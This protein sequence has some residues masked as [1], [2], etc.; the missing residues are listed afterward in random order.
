MLSGSRSIIANTVLALA[1]LLVPRAAQADPQWTLVWDDE[2]MGAAN[3]LPDSTRWTYDLG[4][5]G[6]GNGE[7]ETYTNSTSNVYQTGTGGLVIQALD[8]GGYTSARIK[9]QTLFDQAYGMVE[10]SIQLPAGTTQGS[11]LWPAF[12]M[13]GSNIDTSA[14]PL[15]GEIDMME[16]IGQYNTATQNGGHIHGPIEPG[17]GDYNGGDGVGTTY[18]LPAGEAM[19]TG[20]HVYGVQWNPSSISYFV[21]GVTYQTLS[22][23]SLPAGGAWVFNHPFFIILNLA[24]GGPIGGAVTCSFPQQLQVQY[25]RVFKLTDNGTSAYGGTAPNL[26]GTVQAANYDVY[27]DTTDPGEPGEGFAYNALN[28]SNTSGQYRAGDAISIEDCTDPSALNGGY[29]CDYTSPGQWM[30][31]TVNVTQAGSY[32]LDARVASA[33]SGGTFHFDVDGGEV[34]G[35]LTAPN[36]GGWQTW[37]DVTES[38]ISLTTGK[39]VILLVEDSMLAG[40]A[41]VC[42]FNYFTFSLAT[43]PSS[44]L[45]SA[46]PP[47]PTVTRTSTPS[48]TQT[49]TASRTRTPSPTLSR[50]PTPSA[51]QSWTTTPSRTLSSTETL[52]PSQSQTQSYT[53]SP[54]ATHTTAATLSRTPTT[55]LTQSKTASPQA[56]A[57]DTPAPPPSSTPTA[58]ASAS[59]SPAP[60]PSPTRT[61][62]QTASSS[63]T[64]T[65]TYSGSPSESPSVTLSPNPT[66]SSTPSLSAKP[67]LSGSPSASLTGTLGSSPSPSLTSSPSSSATLTLTPPETLTPYQTL[68]A[69]PSATLT[70]SG[71]PTQT[72]TMSD[73]ATLTVSPT[74]SPF[75]SPMPSQSPSPLPSATLPPAGSFQVLKLQPVPNPQSGPVLGF[76][77]DLEGGTSELEISIFS[78]AMAEIGAWLALGTSVRAGT[79]SP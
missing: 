61:V 11:G 8:N 79:A 32:T 19:N 63:P 53:P 17:G 37:P 38:G 57:S 16:N 33:E 55:S 40:G 68:T 20:F 50:S 23:A 14:W 45:T 10:A 6:W 66:G 72:S 25:V 41:G 42:N 12:W 69:N 74:P 77:V 48:A 31:Y 29:D 5:G 27:D 76:A 62:T 1:L 21:D 28:A 36:T 65:P 22:A 71:A 52:S 46:A 56:T 54:T 3:T 67:S 70:H 44:T 7:L 49:A 13:L 73:T 47:T 35:E 9:T 15:C 60:S 24:I 26:P 58:A 4:G 18:T 75:A 2:F 30:Q 78:V 59:A 34:G 51:T 39:H 64:A 43:T